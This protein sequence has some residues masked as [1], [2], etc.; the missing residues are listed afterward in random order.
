MRNASNSFRLEA[1]SFRENIFRTEDMIH[2]F[3]IMGISGI[4]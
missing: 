1:F 3:I 4:V 2:L